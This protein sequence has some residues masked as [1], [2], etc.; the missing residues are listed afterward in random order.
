MGSFLSLTEARTPVLNPFLLLKVYHLRVI[1][2]VVRIQKP[3]GSG[4]PD[5]AE[6]RPQLS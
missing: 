3:E 2:L 5:K 6:F 4:E 1:P